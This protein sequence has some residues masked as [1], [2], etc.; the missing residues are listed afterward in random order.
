M[1][2]WYQTD[3]EYMVDAPGTCLGV[4]RVMWLEWPLCDTRRRHCRGS[5]DYTDRAALLPF[6]N[7]VR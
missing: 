7:R 1:R 5:D 3:T 4:G 2:R 6:F